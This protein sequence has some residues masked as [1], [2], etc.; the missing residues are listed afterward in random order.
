MCASAAGGAAGA[1]AAAKERPALLGALASRSCAILATRSLSD[2][3]TEDAE[4]RRHRARRGDPGVHPSCRRAS[5]RARWPPIQESC[6]TCRS[7]LPDSSLP[8]ISFQNGHT[9]TA[10]SG[11]HRES[12]ALSLH[13]WIDTRDTLHMWR[14]IAGKGRLR[15][16]P[17]VNHSWHATFYVTSRGNDLADSRTAAG[18]SKSIS[19]RGSPLI[20]A[21]NDGRRR[22]CA[23]A[24]IG[25]ACLRAVEEELT[26]LECRSGSR[27]GPNEVPDAIPSRATKR[28]AP[29]MRT[30]S[31]VLAGARAGDRVLRR[32][33]AA[34][35]SGSAVPCTCS[36]GQWTWRSPGF[37]G[38]RRAHPV[39]SRT[40]GS[41]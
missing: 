41:R 9:L 24:A 17:P 19:I 16:A 6:E 32:S 27:R 38:V 14:Q 31:T 40:A 29:T 23:R 12:A 15:L 2:S 36:G 7:M 10:R 13:D 11:G 3:R 35:S 33:S 30:R 28:T 39:G 18:H 25:R 5:T 37:P 1:R 22:V 21:A 8:C 34:D 4:S 20:I 26:R